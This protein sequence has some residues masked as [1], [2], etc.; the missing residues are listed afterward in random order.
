LP[1][2]RLADD[3]VGTAQELVAFAGLPWRDEVAR[4]VARRHA[5]GGLAGVGRAATGEGAAVPDEEPAGVP[6]GAG[7]APGPGASVALAKGPDRRAAAGARAGAETIV[8]YRPQSRRDLSLVASWRDIATGTVEHRDL[9]WQ[10]FRRDL[11]GAYR[12][13]YLGF[14]WLGIA[15]LLGIVQWLVVRQNRLFQPGDTGVPYPVYVL[16]GTT[17]WALFLGM[18]TAA[19]GS[20]ASSGSLLLQIHFPRESLVFK[21][22]GNQL[23]TFAGGFVVSMVVL[24]AYGIVPS[25]QSVFLPLVLLPMILLGTAIGMVT[26]MVAIVAVDL[27]RILFLVWGLAMWFTP[28][29]Y[30]AGDRQG[31]LE[32]VA[33]WNPLTYLVLAGRELILTGGLPNPAAFA[34]ASALAVLAFLVAGRLFY[35]AEPQLVERML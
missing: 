30:V 15:P 27:D 12:S 2:D 20:L 21:Q 11:L 32:T 10:L 13:S 25:W 29:V 17:M 22:A 9:I 14:A 6:S 33:T 35:A 1:L 3:P 8:R 18:Y 16:I 5:R 34:G 7:G 19:K 26:A 28:V 23:L 4:A 31:W 24:A